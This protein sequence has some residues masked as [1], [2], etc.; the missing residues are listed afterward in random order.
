M[1][2][3]SLRRCACLVALICGLFGGLLSCDS[4]PSTTNPPSLWIGIEQREID[5]VLLDHEPP[6]F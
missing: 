1:A 6:P 5:L 2:F 4:T 3:D